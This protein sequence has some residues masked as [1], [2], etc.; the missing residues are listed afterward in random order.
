MKAVIFDMDG[1]LI[2]T[3]PLNDQHMVIF[4]KELGIEISQD[5]FHNFRGTTAE[6]IWKNLIYTFKLTIPINKL[7]LKSRTRYLEFLASLDNIHP[8]EGVIKLLKEL[9]KNN[10]ALA[11]AS[12]AY[13]KRVHMLLK[14]CRLANFFS[15]VLSGDD[16]KHGKPNPEIYLKTAALLEKDPANCVVFEDATSGILSAKTAGMK[17]VGFKEKSSRQDFSN[18]D[19]IINSFNEITISKLRRL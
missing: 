19:L 4:L 6:N 11:V 17:V 9:K 16:V 10:I 18:A 8:N 12:S 3:E 2:D 1:V 13:N 14:R 5:Y 15:V 7:I